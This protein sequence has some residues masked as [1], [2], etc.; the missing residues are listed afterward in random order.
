MFRVWHF[1]FF[2]AL[3]F[4]TVS[5]CGGPTKPPE[6]QSGRMQAVVSLY[7]MARTVQG[8]AP[9]DQERFKSFIVEKGAKTLERVKVTSAD[10]L[11]TSERDGQPFVVIYGKPPA[12]INPD[13][14]VFE[15]T[16]V[17]GKR[18]VGFGMGHVQEVDEAKFKELVP[19]MP[20]AK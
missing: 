18:Q 2:L 20:A 12:G 10:E 5:G 1:A 4:G 3:V 17:D 13:V 19:S 8:R 9:A 7:G 6:T 14:L 15:Q 16:G 11:L